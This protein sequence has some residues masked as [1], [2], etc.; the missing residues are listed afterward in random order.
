MGILGCVLLCAALLT[1]LPVAFA[2]AI[3]GFAGFALVVSPLAAMSLITV[4]L[5][6]TFANYTLI[7][8]P[9]FVLMGQVS[10][11]SGISRSLFSTAYHVAG[12]AAGR[13]G[14]GHGGGLHGVWRHL[15][16]RPGHGG[17]D[18]VGRAAGNAPL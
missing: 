18:G 3:V 13:T 17:H 14:D 7:V 15:R 8:I 11:H 4:D 16:L 6:D 2:M 10:F 12:A 5:Y 1:S 9:L